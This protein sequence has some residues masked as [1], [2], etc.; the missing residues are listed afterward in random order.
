MPVPFSF[1]MSLR[2]DLYSFSSSVS[3]SFSLAVSFLSLDLFLSSLSFSLLLWLPS[4]RQP[5]MRST[6][7]MASF[8]KRAELPF[9]Y[10][11]VAGVQQRQPGSHRLL[12]LPAFRS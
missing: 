12:R 6:V 1:R 7:A 11:A 8:W 5:S 4:A 10:H 3:S 2:F 9:L